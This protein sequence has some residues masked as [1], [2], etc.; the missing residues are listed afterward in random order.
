MENPFRYGEEVTGEDFCNRR[1][2]I[3]R[4]TDYIGAANKVLL[5]SPRRWGKTSLIKETISRLPK[6]K[7]LIIY[8]DLYPILKEE[9]FSQ[10]VAQGFARSLAS[11]LQKAVATLRSLLTSFIP[12]VT[13]DA[14][15]EA[16]FEFGFD[17]TKKGTALAEEL[18]DAIE[19]SARKSKKRAVVILDEFQQVGEL[20]DDR[21]EKVLRSKIQAQRHVCYIF[22]G[23][24]RH[25]LVEMF[26]NPSRPFYKSA[27]H[28]P[29]GAIPPE[30]MKTFISKKFE[31]RGRVADDAAL[32]EILETAENHSYHVQQLCF[33]IWETAAERR[34][35]DRETISN[36][37]E[38]ILVSENAS[39]HNT[40]S[41]LTR[42]QKLA[43]K[44]LAGIRAGETP[45]SMDFL[46]RAGLSSADAFRKA[47]ESLVA[48]EL[49]EK[50]NG[51]YRISDVFLKRWLSKL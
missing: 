44:A 14:S 40:W 39:Y 37:V 22:A 26:S 10:I 6:R 48:K 13:L 30:E 34:R 16:N 28:F 32:A 38:R 1:K 42:S 9:H 27:I 36:A 15:G 11:P 29:L 18:L 2:E 3:R 20:A 33:H 49:V 47:L 46:N 4:L 50:E 31:A 45:F 21:L 25:L 35:I 8:A 51:G 12:K 24:K 5:Y 19:E 7:H 41:L 23:S 43:L 17:S